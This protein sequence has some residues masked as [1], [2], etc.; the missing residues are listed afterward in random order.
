MEKHNIALLG[1]D[2]G[3]NRESA[4]RDIEHAAIGTVG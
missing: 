3:L 4:L 2:R 1:L